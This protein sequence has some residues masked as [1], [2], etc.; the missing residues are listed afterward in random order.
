MANQVQAAPK[1][2][3]FEKLV[4]WVKQNP[5]KGVIIP[6]ADVETIMGVPY[7]KNCGCLN[8]RYSYQVKK[9]N[10]KLLQSALALDA[11]QGYGY[12]VMNDNQYVD[13][14]RRK[15]NTGLKYILSAKE[16]GDNT[17]ISALTGAEYKEWENTFNTITNAC[18]YLSFIPSPT[19]TLSKNKKVVNP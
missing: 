16:Y 4:D 2:Q 18:G 8:S 9:A 12:R 1:M 19:I 11:I 10:E 14:M 17:N 6:H 13:V 3:P 7:R 15:F 5:T